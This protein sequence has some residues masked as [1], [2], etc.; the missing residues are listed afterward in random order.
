MKSKFLRH[1]RTTQER[2]ANSKGFR[3]EYKVRARRNQKNLV[4]AWDDIWNRSQRSWKKHRKTQY[5]TNG[6]E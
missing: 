1:P 5:K 2:R 6:R 4:E 3:H